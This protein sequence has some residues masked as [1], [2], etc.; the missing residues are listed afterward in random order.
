MHLPNALRPAESVCRSRHRRR[1]V[2]FF[3]I[4]YLESPNPTTRTTVNKRR[5]CTGGMPQQ[6][7]RTS[8][9]AIFF[10]RSSD[11]GAIAA[12]PL[13]QIRS[14]FPSRTYLS[15]AL[16]AFG[17][18]T[19]QPPPHDPV[20]RSFAGSVLV[21]LRSIFPSGTYLSKQCSV[22]IRL[23]TQLPPPHNPVRRSFAVR[24]DT[25]SR[26]RMHPHPYAPAPARP[27][28]A[29]DEHAPNRDG[30]PARSFFTLFSLFF[31]EKIW[32]FG[33]GIY[34]CN[35]ELAHLSLP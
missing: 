20:R 35:Q 9:H 7:S 25:R 18:E 2:P 24:I 6:A 31:V 17:Q 22:C 4:R 21:Q 5:A 19:Q 23:K 34:L 32:F 1:V 12:P 28:H 29:S 15:G 14:I 33:G 11:A 16:S 27:P 26:G 3:F 13:A 8:G 30:I 10:D